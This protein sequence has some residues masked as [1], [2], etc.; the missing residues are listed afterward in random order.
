MKTPVVLVAV[1]LA[2]AILLSASLLI[3]TGARGENALGR[4]SAQPQ[5][6]VLPGPAPDTG[7]KVA[8]LEQR[9]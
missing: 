1:S 3:A 6:W 5:N 7:Y 2:M 9:I 4:I 8:I